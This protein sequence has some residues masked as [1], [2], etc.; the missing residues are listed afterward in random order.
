LIR[1]GKLHANFVWVEVLELWII[2]D[3]P[4]NVREDV[5]ITATFKLFGCVIVKV[6]HEACPFRVVFIDEV[7]DDKAELAAGTVQELLSCAGDVTRNHF[8]SAVRL[9]RFVFPASRFLEADW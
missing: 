1:K 2:L 3:T 7:V 9:F 8:C 6:V 5:A 4:V